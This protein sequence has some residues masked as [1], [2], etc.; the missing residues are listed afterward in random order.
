MTGPVASRR[1]QGFALVEALA[2]LVVV[3]MI[4]LMLIA[5][6]T[7]GR[8]V[9]ERIDTREAQGETLDSAQ[10]T[11]RDRIEQ[12]FPQTRFDQ[13]PPYIDFRGTSQRLIFLANPPQA[14][15]PAPIRRYS[16]ALNTTGELVLSSISDVGPAERAIETRQVLLAGVRQIDLA[17]LGPVQANRAANWRPTWYDNTSLPQLVR[18]RLAFEPGD[19]RVWPD[20]L[21]HPR[22]TIDTACLLNTITHR[23]KGRQ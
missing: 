15:R 20:L 19:A 23:C 14:E 22:A 3:G 9:W 5:G 18:V 13:S 8:R 2:S 12:T 11:L 21:I 4:G 10:T 17:Y 6:V 1:S 16:L 7:T